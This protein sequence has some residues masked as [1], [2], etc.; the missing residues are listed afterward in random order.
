MKKKGV[1]CL[2]SMFPFWVM[3]FKLSKKVHCLQFCAD[4]SKKYKSIK[5]IYIY[6]SE[7]SRHALSESGIGYYAMTY[8]FRDIRV[9]SRGILLNFFWFCIFF[10][11][12]IA[13]ISWTVAETP[14]S[15]IISWKSVMRTFRCI[16]VN[17]FNRFRFL[18]EV[19]IKLQKIYFFGQFKDHNSGGKNG[20]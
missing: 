18:A 20:N 9:W 4:L 3:V 17:Y 14:I 13:S 12:L 16:Y 8:C 10:Y 7:R 2:V 6:A 19:S 15:H 5:S 1:I 11:I